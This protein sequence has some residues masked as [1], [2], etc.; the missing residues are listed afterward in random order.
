MFVWFRYVIWIVALADS[1]TCTQDLLVSRN[2]RTSTWPFKKGEGQHLT[3][4]PTFREAEFSQ[5]AGQSVDSIDIQLW[6][7]T[8][9]QLTHESVKD[10]QVRMHSQV[11]H[12][13]W[14]FD[15]SVCKASDWAA[16]G[17]VKVHSRWQFYTV[18]ES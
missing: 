12:K 1:T 4:K 8:A 17:Q 18:L 15:L 3:S 14:Q 7:K 11:Q 5:L 13:A 10:T 2:W 16:L 9:I 6:V